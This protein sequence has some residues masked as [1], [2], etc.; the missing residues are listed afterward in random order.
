MKE[1]TIGTL[2][3]RLYRVE[4]ENRRFKR[5]GSV[6]LVGVAA[7]MLMAQAVSK[8]QV[9]G[10]DRFPLLDAKGMT[11]AEMSV[12]ADGSPTNIST[13]WSGTAGSDSKKPAVISATPTTFLTIRPAL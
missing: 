2:A 8:S 5:V 10:A 6:S 4:Q 3:R 9:V 12:L 11:R 1:P 7:L 13:P